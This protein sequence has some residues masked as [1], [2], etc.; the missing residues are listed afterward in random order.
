[1]S[2]EAPRVSVVLTTYKR[3][4]VLGR[5]IE[6]VLAQTVPNWELLVVDDEPSDET[7]RIVGSFGDSRVYYLAHDKN[8]GLCAARNTGIRASRGEYVAFLDDDD[9]FL[10]RKLELQAAALDRLPTEVGV[11]SCFEQVTSRGGALVDRAIP[12]EG[13]V[14]RLLARD[15]VVRMQLLLVRRVCFD[16]VGLFDERLQMHDDFDM[17]LRL[18]R[19]FRFATVPEQ[20]VGIIG[21]PGSMSTNVHKRIDAL[22]MMIA[23]H[24]ELREQRIPRGRWERRLARHYGEIG[25]TTEWRRHLVR[26]LI[27]NPFS[28]SSWLAIVGGPSAHMRLAKLRGTIAR[29]TRFRRA[30]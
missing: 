24:P 11:V 14:H 28:G 1:M 20:L 23:S 8:R 17:T 12:L 27:A 16:R 15:D 3:Q 2:A 25:D 21:T 18:S 26:S 9:V 4:A 10:P 22:E 5:A 6:S 30:Q 7:D 19:S 13:D 29:A